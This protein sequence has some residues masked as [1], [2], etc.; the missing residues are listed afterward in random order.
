MTITKT[1]LQGNFEKFTYKNGHWSM[2]LRA[3]N[4]LNAEEAK[5]DFIFDTGA[6]TTIINPSYF[7][8]HDGVLAEYKMLSGEVF[9]TPR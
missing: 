7:E 6:N 3:M 9:V 1:F 8:K 5:I 2:Q 4:S